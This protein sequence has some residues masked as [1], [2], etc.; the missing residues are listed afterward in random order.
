[1]PSPLHQTFAN[2][3]TILGRTQGTLRTMAPE[4]A[5]KTGRDDVALGG[6]SALRARHQMFCRTV[7]MSRL[8]LGESMCLRKGHQDLLAT[9]E[10]R[11]RSSGQTERGTRDLTSVVDIEGFKSMRSPLAPRAKTGDQSSD[12]HWQE[13]PVQSGSGRWF[14]VLI[15]SRDS[16]STQTVHQ[17]H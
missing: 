14:F 10:H 3:L 5:E 17:E 15:A 1:V 16:G 12:S 4:I 6:V 11:S 7:Q 13:P 9:W 8:A 2:P